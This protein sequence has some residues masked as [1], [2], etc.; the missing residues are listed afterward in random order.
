MLRQIVAQSCPTARNPSAS[1]KDSDGNW[2]RTG[3]LLQ[4]MQRRSCKLLDSEQS[5]NSKTQV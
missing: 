4:D 2:A 3:V 1:L 5:I